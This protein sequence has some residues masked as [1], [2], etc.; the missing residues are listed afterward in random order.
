M[1]SSIKNIGTDLV[2]ISRIAKLYNKYQ[3]KFAIKI[4]SELEIEKFKIINYS[5][6]INYLAK[7]LRPKKH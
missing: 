2:Q 3:D 4:L 5:K 6:K 7:G 1:N